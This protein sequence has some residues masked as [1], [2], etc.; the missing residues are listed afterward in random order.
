[1]NLEKIGQVMDLVQQFEQRANE[2]VYAETSENGGDI[3]VGTAA[4]GALRRTSMELTRALA[5]LRRP[6]N[7]PGVYRLNPCTLSR[8]ISRQPI[9][10]DGFSGLCI[11]SIK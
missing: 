1:L 9:V 7:G 6:G 3:I 11:A 2:V 8:A 4:T 10:K 5:D